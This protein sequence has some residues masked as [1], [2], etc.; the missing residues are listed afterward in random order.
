MRSLHG[1]V[2]YE[3]TLAGHAWKTRG[4]RIKTRL[5]KGSWS[6]RTF[7]LAIFCLHV[8]FEKHFVLLLDRVLLEEVGHVLG[9]ESQRVAGPGVRRVLLDGGENFSAP[10]ARER[11]ASSDMQGASQGEHQGPV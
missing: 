4:E 11:L 1:E 5:H 3:I 7:P 6:G 9:E 8:A 2:V 10:A